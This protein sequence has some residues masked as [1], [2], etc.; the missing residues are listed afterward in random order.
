MIFILLLF[1]LATLVLNSPQAVA[2]FCPTCDPGLPEG[3]NDVGLGPF[4]GD[5]FLKISSAT[6]SRFYKLTTDFKE[7]VTTDPKQNQWDVD[8]GAAIVFRF[9]NASSGA[10]PP[11][12]PNGDSDDVFL[13]QIAYDAK[14]ASPS[15]EGYLIA[16]LYNSTS[17]PANNTNFTIYATADTTASGAARSGV[18]RV[19]VNITSSTLGVTDYIASSD[20]GTHVGA[21]TYDSRIGAGY[22]RSWMNV[23]NF[24]TFNDSTYLYNE[25][26][27][28]RGD[29]VYAELKT[30]SSAWN[31]TDANGAVISFVS[32]GSTI[33][34]FTV[35]VSFTN[36]T[37][38]TSWTMPLA[39]DLN[40]YKA[41]LTITGTTSAF[42]GTYTAHILNALNDLIISNGSTIILNGT[43][44]YENV[45]LSNNSKISVGYGT[46]WIQA[47][48]EI[49]IN[50]GSYIM[51]NGTGLAGGA[52]GLGSTGAGSA[53]TGTGAGGGGA[54]VAGGGGGAGHGGTGGDGG[55]SAATGGVTNGSSSARD[56]EVGAGAG[57]GAGNTFGNQNARGGAGGAGGGVI[58]LEADDNITIDGIITADGTAGARGGTAGICQD[59]P[60]LSASAGGG[61]GGSGGTIVLNSSKITITGTVL[62]RGGVGGNAVTGISNPGSGGGGGGGG[63]I[64][65]FGTTLDNKGTLSAIGNV[66]G[67]GATEG[68]DGSSGTIH[69]ATGER[70]TILQNT[71][72]GYVSNDTATFDFTKISDPDGEVSDTNTTFWVE[73]EF[74]LLHDANYPR[75]NGGNNSAIN[76]YLQRGDVL[77]FSFQLIDEYERT[78]ANKAVNI[79]ANTSA[80]AEHNATNATTNAAGKIS[81]SFT[82]SKDWIG[83]YSNTTPGAIETRDY[84]LHIHYPLTAMLATDGSY[85]ENS[86]QSNMFDVSSKL[87]M[88]V[89]VQNSST[90]TKD[91][92]DDSTEASTYQIGQDTA[93]VWAHVH[94]V[95]SEDQNGKNVTVFVYAYNKDRSNNNTGFSGSTGADGWTT[96]LGSILAQGPANTWNFDTDVG[97]DA[98]NNSGTV[99]QQVTFFTVLPVNV[100]Y[101]L[102]FNNTGPINNGNLTA[103]WSCVQ[104]RGNATYVAWTFSDTEPLLTGQFNTSV[105][106]YNINITQKTSSAT[107]LAFSTGF[108]AN[109]TANEQDI[110]KGL[111]EKR[112]FP[113]FSFGDVKRYVIKLAAEYT[114]VRFTNNITWSEGSYRLTITNNKTG[115]NAVNISTSIV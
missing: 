61:G 89:H 3:A 79:S 23:T 73:E 60:C 13:I 106:R 72:F 81:G 103:R 67:D 5:T 84:G 58:V 112:N 78:F 71:G 105:A 35:N 52:G 16:T 85:G 64:K 2:P 74:T 42:K 90:L 9:L 91:N 69:L 70:W 98:S 57:G 49:L 83:S 39:A 110:S 37:Y 82:I 53:G 45:I 92:M 43:Q 34:S 93:Y 40:N 88:D 65:I 30:N 115:V 54:V 97:A 76:Q 100:T 33:A 24:T 50:A 27:F 109:V 14:A 12:V 102:T 86:T 55:G 29:V 108:C 1:T 15:N 18:A 41:T 63:R 99:N 11:P 95:R 32:S 111:F 68:S 101:A 10:S 113:A 4:R 104:D 75:L 38:R 21:A 31:A 25:T 46:L 19:V 114:N 48:G 22:L 51:A 77:N 44:N 59:T 87:F 66:G 7:G 17:A 36:N 8:P 62:A 94:N 47:D 107:Y 96:L 56:W 6:G 26:R 20:R 80:G 28:M